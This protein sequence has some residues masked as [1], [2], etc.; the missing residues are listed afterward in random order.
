MPLQILKT[1]C[2]LLISD[3]GFESYTRKTC[4]I[5]L[6]RS[7]LTYVL[8]NKIYLSLFDCFTGLNRQTLPTL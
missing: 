6:T 1:S 5:S 3:S 4:Q 2:A 7:L 8:A